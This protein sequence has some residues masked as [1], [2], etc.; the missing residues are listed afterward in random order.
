MPISIAVV[1]GKGG[2]GKTTVALNLGIA[3]AQLGKDVTILDA[4]VEVASIGLQLGLDASKP[5][6]HSVLAGE[7]SVKDAIH[8]VA[9]AKVIAGG[10]RLE[11]L[12]RVDLGKFKDIASALLNDTD[13]LVIDVPPGLGADT[14]T[15]LS[16]AHAVILATTPD[17][18]SLSG[19]L[20]AKSLAEHFGARILGAVVNRVTDDRTELSGKEVSNVLGADVLAIIPED[21]EIRRAAAFGQPVVVMYPDS[22]ASQ[23]IRK[24][25]ADLEDITTV[26]GVEYVLSQP[27]KGGEKWPG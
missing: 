25:A 5:T 13:I 27:K 3:L 18:T 19:T 24:L 20:K 15:A 17:I 7:A 2:V 23:A 11:S 1:S 12:R 10:M 22:P 16:A 26:N 14:I 4:N 9:G 21:P 8:K 6:L